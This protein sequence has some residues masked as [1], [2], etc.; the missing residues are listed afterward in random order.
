VNVEYTLLDQ[1][2]AEAELGK[3]SGEPDEYGHKSDR[4]KVSWEEK[5]SQ[6]HLPKVVQ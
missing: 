2:G 5:A 1:S 3:Y 6:D 4:A